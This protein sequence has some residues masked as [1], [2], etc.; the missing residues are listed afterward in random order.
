MNEETSIRS[1]KL[2]FLTIGLLLIITASS[3][4]STCNVCKLVVYVDGSNAPIVAASMPDVLSIGDL[5]LAG[6]LIA[7][8]LSALAFPMN[9]SNFPPTGAL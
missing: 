5:V 7:A 1:S 4:T 9:F 2:M 8:A 6:T 3:E